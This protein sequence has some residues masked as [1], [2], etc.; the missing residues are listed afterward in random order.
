MN[1]ERRKLIRQATKLIVQAAGLIQQAADE[2]WSYF[3][4]MSASMQS[5][6][7]GQRADCAAADLAE[8]VGDLNSAVCILTDTTE[9][10]DA[11]LG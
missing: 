7:R 1:A 3:Q 11:V 4:N 6:E 10:G 8:V 9:G 5:S 2:E